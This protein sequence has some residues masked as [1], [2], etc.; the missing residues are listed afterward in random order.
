MEK[1]YK[2]IAITLLISY[3]LSYAMENEN[4]ENMKKERTFTLRELVMDNKV[5]VIPCGFPSGYELHLNGRNIDKIEKNT[6]QDFKKE[7]IVVIFLQRN[8]IRKIP[9]SIGNFNRLDILDLGN[10]Q[11]GEL[12][13]SMRRLIKLR[14]LSLNDNLF[15]KIPTFIYKLHLIYLD[16]DNNKITELSDS[17]DTCTDLSYFWLSN[18]NITKIPET[19][20][21]LKHIYQLNLDGNRF[22]WEEQDR[23]RTLLPNANIDL[24]NQQ[25]N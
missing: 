4:N 1:N 3:S 17:I 5:K 2:L 24:D 16:L 11:I 18:N 21:N 15:I 6:L 22:S 20:R 7:N 10:N 14:S 9:T 19:M 12:P 8:N 23:T 13:G 25:E